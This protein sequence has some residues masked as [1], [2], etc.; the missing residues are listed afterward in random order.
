VAEASVEGAAVADLAEVE[1]LAAVSVV[2]A[3]VEVE[4]VVVGKPILNPFQ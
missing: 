2:E 3:S 1:A 4:P